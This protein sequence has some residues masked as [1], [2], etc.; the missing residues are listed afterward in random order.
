MSDDP[1]DY[2]VGWSTP[3][4][5]VITCLRGVL[6]MTLVYRRFSLPLTRLYAPVYNGPSG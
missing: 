2:A 3:R 5:Q 6:D 4:K 1:S